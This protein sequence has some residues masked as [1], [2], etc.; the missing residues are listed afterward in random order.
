MFPEPASYEDYVPKAWNDK[1]IITI[2]ANEKPPVF[3]TTLGV[4]TKPE[5]LSLLIL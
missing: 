5:R 3:V 4:V 1:Y 2:I